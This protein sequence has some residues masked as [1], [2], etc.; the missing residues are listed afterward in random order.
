MTLLEQYKK[1]HAILTTLLAERSACEV[2]APSTVIPHG[3]YLHI[4]RDALTTLES[5]INYLENKKPR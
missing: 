2:E 1:D 4:L 5:M 3:I